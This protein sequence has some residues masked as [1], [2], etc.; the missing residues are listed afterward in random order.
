MNAEQNPYRTP[1][2]LGV[3]VPENLV[4]QMR[5]LERQYSERYHQLLQD[6]LMALYLPA[7]FAADMWMYTRE[8]SHALATFFV[9]CMYIVIEAVRQCLQTEQEFPQRMHELR[10][11]VSQ[12]W[13][14]KHFE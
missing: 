4:H 6:V 3:V 7:G 12:E 1:E 5:E 13:V 14:R 8:E 10:S 9:P 11:A 2:Y